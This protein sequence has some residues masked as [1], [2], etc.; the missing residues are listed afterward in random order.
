MK[1]Y[2]EK[3]DR[4]PE[5]NINFP[6]RPRRDRA[7]ERLMRQTPRCPYLH[8]T[9]ADAMKLRVPQFACIPKPIYDTFKCRVSVGVCISEPSICTI[10]DRSNI[11]YC[12]KEADEAKAKSRPK[13]KTENVDKQSEKRPVQ[14]PPKK[15]FR[16]KLKRFLP[17]TKSKKK[18]SPSPPSPPTPPPPVEGFKTFSKAVCDEATKENVI[19]HYLLSGDSTTKCGE[20]PSKSIKPDNKI[21]EGTAPQE[22]VRKEGKTADKKKQHNKN[23]LGPKHSSGSSVT[24]AKG[25]KKSKNNKSAKNLEK[26]NAEVK[27]KEEH[28]K[29][30]K[31][32]NKKKPA[33]GSLTNVKE[34]H[35]EQSAKESAVSTK[36]STKNPTEC[37]SFPEL[38]S[39]CEAEKEEKGKVKKG[40]SGIKEPQSKN[41]LSSKKGSVNLDKGAKKGNKKPKKNKSSKNLNRSADKDANASSQKISFH[42]LV[43][44]MCDVEKSKKGKAEKEDSGIKE[45][46]SKIKLSPKKSGNSLEGHKKP[47]KNKSYKNLKGST[48]KKD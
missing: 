4:E 33:G 37:I 13:Q 48:S 43:K 6:M 40:S 18:E 10:L 42:E 8:K 29:G 46:R 7:C 3:E 1:K 20:L 32:Q 28:P 9:Q 44:C 19:E 25:Q 2:N 35:K 30:K 34:N 14:E 24:S 23:K 22:Q 47:K 31:P 39:M 11:D 27:A 12:V 26:S 21:V 16:E 17:F 15:N 5:L 36:K 45:P 41:K 38:K